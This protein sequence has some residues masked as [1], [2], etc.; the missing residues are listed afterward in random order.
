MGPRYG[1]RDPYHGT[2]IFR[3]PFENGSGMGPAYHQGVPLLRVPE[4]RIDRFGDRGECQLY[5]PP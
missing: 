5:Y 1:K 3:V 2:H 4:N